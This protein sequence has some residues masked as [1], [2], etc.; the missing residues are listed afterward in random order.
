MHLKKLISC[1]DKW[2]VLVAL[3]AVFHVYMVPYTKVEE[4]FNTQA[5]HDFLYHRQHLEKY[6]HFDFPGVVPRT[7][8]GALVIALVSAPVVFVLQLLHLPKIY[9]LY[10]VRLIL[11]AAVLG[12]LS[13]LRT[14]VRKKF[15][16]EVSTAFAIITAVQFHLLFYASRPLPNVFALALGS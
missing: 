4:S 14:Q 12:S 6:D 8:L 15:G 16:N 5:M 1:F 2:D 3:I 11:G 13:A 9:S 7:F 10:T